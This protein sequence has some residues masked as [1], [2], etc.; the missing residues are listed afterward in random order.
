[1]SRL[2]LLLSAFLLFPISAAAQSV[3]IGVGGTD[4][5]AVQGLLRDAIDEL[6]ALDD[7]VDAADSR[8]VQRDLHRKVMRIEELLEDASRLAA[9][10]GGLS[11]SVVVHDPNP[12]RDTVVIVD[13]HHNRGG[14]IVVDQQID[15]G[16]VIIVDDGPI[17][18][19][20][21]DFDAVLRA[22]DDESFS[23]GKLDVLRDASRARWFTVS[24][25]QRL[26]KSFTFGKDMVDAGALLFSRT[27]DQEN[28]Y[29]VYSVFTFESDKDKLRQRVGR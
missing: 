1:V 2:A 12:V 4:P 9:H 19:S 11:A 28:W 5:H 20:S 27:V 25:V 6:R 14:V 23:S 22:L 8:S 3:G 15:P 13:E 24:Q 29:L 21:S 17:A 16:P 10:G 7:L 26:I 18:C